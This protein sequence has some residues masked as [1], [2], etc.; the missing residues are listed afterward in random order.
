MLNPSQVPFLTILNSCFPASKTVEYSK[1]P[2][3][4]CFNWVSGL[5]LFQFWNDPAINHLFFPPD[6]LTNSSAIISPVSGDSSFGGSTFV[7]GFT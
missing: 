7:T 6:W 5:L 4:K 3:T 2:S 1:N